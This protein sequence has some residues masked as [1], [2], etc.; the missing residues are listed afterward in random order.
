MATGRSTGYQMTEDATSPAFTQQLA[1]VMLGGQ[2]SALTSGRTGWLICL[3]S[4][5]SL[6]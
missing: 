5:P 2:I 1:A 6:E 4:L 3:E